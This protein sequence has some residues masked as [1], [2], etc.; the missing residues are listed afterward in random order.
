[1]SYKRPALADRELAALCNL[2]HLTQLDLMGTR[3][4]SYL[5]VKTLLERSADHLVLLDISYCEQ[6][7]N[8]LDD[9]AQLRRTYP[10]CNIILSHT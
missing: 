4:V 5:A 3:N 1:L 9:L 6:L 10:R 2:S 7:E 8:A